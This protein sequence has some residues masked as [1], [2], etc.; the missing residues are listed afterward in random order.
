MKWRPAS[1]LPDAESV[2]GAA[3]PEHRGIGYESH[4]RGDH[5]GAE[6][7]RQQAPGIQAQ[8]LSEGPPAAQLRVP[9]D[10][11]GHQEAGHD[12]RA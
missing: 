6:V 12:L 3:L 4:A 9:Q 11:D 2:Q 1:P 10:G 5:V 8:L 7:N